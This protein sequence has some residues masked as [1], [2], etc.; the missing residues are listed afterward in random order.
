MRGRRW[1]VLVQGVLLVSPILPMVLLAHP[2]PQ[3]T[4]QEGHHSQQDTPYYQPTRD[5]NAG[6]ELQSQHNTQQQQQQQQQHHTQQNTYDHLQPQLQPI[7][8]PQ[9]EPQSQ[10]NPHN[11]SQPHQLQPVYK[12]PQPQTQQKTHNPPHDD[13]PPQQQQ[14]HHKLTIQ[15]T[16]L[17][18]PQRQEEKDDSGEAEVQSRQLTQQHQ[19]EQILTVADAL[20][21]LP[22]ILPNFNNLHTNNDLNYNNY[23]QQLVAPNLNPYGIFGEVL[24][25]GVTIRHFLQVL[26]DNGILDPQWSVW[27]DYLEV[28][29]HEL[30]ETDIV[31]FLIYRNLTTE[32]DDEMHTTLTT[33]LLD[34]IG[35]FI[36]NIYEGIRYVM[37]GYSIF[38]W[39]DRSTTDFQRWENTTQPPFNLTEELEALTTI[40]EVE[41]P[42]NPKLPLGVISIQEY[43]PYVV[44]VNALMA[45]GWKMLFCEYEVWCFVGM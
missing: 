44:G 11:P 45:L 41:D 36:W 26:H 32:Y 7:Y 42:A 28:M 6:L 12:P 20:Q 23:H 31:K 29:G 37:Q 39:W 8:K 2:T 17:Q 40:H 14:E 15:D 21:K 5:N 25:G 10:Q 27:L 3:D 13:T 24:Q 4:H 33:S 16:L 9:S 38:D 34:P 22:Q 19:N 1:S 43:D 30:M 18:E 35:K